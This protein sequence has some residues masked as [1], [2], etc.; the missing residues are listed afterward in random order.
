[1]TKMIYIY[2]ATKMMRNILTWFKFKWIDI[3]WIITGRRNVLLW[4]LYNNDYYDYYYNF[5]PISLIS[6]F[7]V[8]STRHD[9]SQVMCSRNILYRNDFVQSCPTL[10]ILQHIWNN[11]NSKFVTINYSEMLFY[12]NFDVGIY[13][14]ITTIF[15]GLSWYLC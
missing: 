12:T 6:I 5:N 8:V 1:M 10:I 15:G 2:T 3:I 11:V 13:A 7:L 4:S 9:V 14:M